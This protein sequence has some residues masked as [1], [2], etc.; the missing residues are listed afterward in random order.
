MK[1]VLT[2]IVLALLA[3]PLYSRQQL[4]SLLEELDKELEKKESYTQQKLREIERSKQLIKDENP[5]HAAQRYER[6]L[7]LFEEYKTLNFD[8]AF[9]Y[10]NKLAHE[11]KVLNEPQKINEAHINLSFILLSSGMFIEA[12]KVIDSIAVDQLNER[13]KIEFYTLKARYY[14]DLCNFVKNAHYCA[15]YTQAGNRYADS[16]LVLAQKG[17]YAYHFISGLRNLHLE[18]HQ[19][20]LLDYSNLLH[21]HALN[22]HEYAIIGSTLSYLY[23][24][25]QDEHRGIEMLIK[26][27][28]SDIKNATKEN[29]AIFKL[30]ELLFEKGDNRRAYKY[31][32]TAMEDAEY[33]GARHR[34]F[35]V[36]SLLPIIEGKQLALLEEQRSTIFNYAVTLTGLIV[37][38]IAFVVV[39]IRQNR[40]LKRAKDALSAANDQLLHANEALVKANSDLREA[41][42]I[43]DEY[44]GYYFNFSSEY[45]DKIGRFKKA[46]E[47][48]LANERHT[49]IKKIVAK[50]DP[51][52]ERE[53]LA[54]RFDQVFV[55]LF[56][57]FVAGFNALFE[58]KDRITLHQGQLLNTELRIFALIRLG[59]HDNDKIAN[60]LNFSVNTIYSYKT[61]IKNRSIVAN[62]DFEDKIMEIKADVN[63]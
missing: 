42:K 56:P 24:V 14:Y 16:A 59:I 30:A 7:S 13:K 52:K 53:N 32:L 18:D 2:F 61:R 55:N 11:A 57:N 54:E 34:Q 9:V 37:I 21:H 1:P 28:I 12:K 50:I 47:Q 46:I 35:E 6:E 41:N 10:A 5:S 27:A 48:Q 63:E 23:F 60:I 29:V 62:H 36:G 40:R 51:R 44:I 22:K 39:T 33:Y 20:A 45:I 26:A 8:S 19:Q 31:I 58:E 25:L 15:G 43:K 3:L 49:E 17:T 4:D 38:I